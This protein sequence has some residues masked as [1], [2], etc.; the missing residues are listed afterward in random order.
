MD[1]GVHIPEHSKYL[2]YMFLMG[3]N[4]HGFWDN[5]LGV[6]APLQS[7]DGLDVVSVDILFYVAHRKL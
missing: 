6:N 3:Y 1:A 4:Y 7:R 5:K 2:D